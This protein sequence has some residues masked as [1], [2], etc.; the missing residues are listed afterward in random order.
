MLRGVSDPVAFFITWSCYG[1][2]LHGD[3]RGSVDRVHNAYDT[4]TLPAD[5][6]RRRGAEKLLQDS[7]STFDDRARD[8]IRDTIEAHCRYRGWE[9]MAVNARSNH[10]HVVLGYAGIDPETIMGQLK[11]WCSRRLREARIVKPGAAVWTRHGS[12]RYLWDQHIPAAV[13]YVEDGQDMEGSAMSPRAAGA[14][15]LNARE[16]SAERWRKEGVCRS[17]PGL[18]LGSD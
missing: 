18:A 8:L 12:T 14:R 17:D 15:G 3:P 7:P 16:A 6:R 2:W 4:P 1:N 13:A 9:L 11:A 10:V 5:P